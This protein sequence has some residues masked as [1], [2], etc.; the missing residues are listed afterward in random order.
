MARRHM[1]NAL[2]FNREHE[3]NEQRF[4]QLCA[5]PFSAIGFTTGCNHVSY[6]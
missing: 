2:F 5:H 3:V 4:V 1:C 6:E